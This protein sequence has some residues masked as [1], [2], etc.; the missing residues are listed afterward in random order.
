MCVCTHFGPHSKGRKSANC[1]TKISQRFAP[2]SAKKFARI[3][4]SRIMV[5]MICRKQPH[6]KP[7]KTKKTMLAIPPSPGGGVKT[8]RAD[9]QEGDKDS[10][11]SVFRVRRFTESP[12]SLHWIA[13][14][15]EILIPNPPFT[16]LRHPFSLKSP[17]F[18]WKVPRRIPFPKIG[19]EKKGVSGLNDS[20][21]TGSLPN[22]TRVWGKSHQSRRLIFDS[23]W[24]GTL[25]FFADCE[26]FLAPELCEIRTNDPNARP[27]CRKIRL[28]MLWSLKM[29]HDIAA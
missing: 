28:A 2:V 15:V 29:F 1:F 22:K 21:V 14:P 3:S 25:G 26:P 9:F 16:E 12:G 27:P 7:P 23:F 13:F 10:N 19:S 17:S 24:V 6:Q 18:Q 11:F 20:R 8:I 5:I 4:L